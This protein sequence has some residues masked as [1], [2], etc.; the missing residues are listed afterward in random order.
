MPEPPQG[1]SVC[2]NYLKVDVIIDGQQTDS[3]VGGRQRA[4]ELEFARTAAKL[5]DRM[6]G[7]PEPG[8]HYKIKLEWH[9]ASPTECK[10]K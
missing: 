6:K 5:C 9:P 4:L 8:G 3:F 1:E 10:H 2:D 7:F